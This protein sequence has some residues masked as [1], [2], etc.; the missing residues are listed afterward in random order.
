M[1][2]P[3]AHGPAGADDAALTELLDLDGRALHAYWHEAFGRVEQ[4]LTA[5]RITRPRI[6]DLGAGSGIATIALAERFAGSDVLAVDVSDGMV[7]H[8]RGKAADRGLARVRVVRADLDGAWPDTG[9]VDL[10]WASM[11]LHHLGD[12]PRVLRDVFGAT[13]PGGFVAVAEFDEPL[14]FLP[15]DVGIGTPGLERRC[16]DLLAEVHAHDVPEIGADWPS[17]LTATGFELVEERA[18][19]IDL[20]PPHGAPA[21][22]YAR[23]W[24]QRLADGVGDG[25]SADDQATLAA[26]LGDGPAS[27]G[28]RD[29]LHVRGVRTLTIARRPA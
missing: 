21:V 16:L 8:I 2:H 14:R 4:A 6:L 24:M 3:H 28:H 18:I 7:E 29:D 5:A 27:I 10:T 26:L 13:R 15:D 1:S 25:L 11:S 12:P 23:R 9:I 22:E 17:R 19:A 20:R